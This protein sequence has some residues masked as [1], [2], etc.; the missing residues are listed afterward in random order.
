MNLTARH[1][2]PIIHQLNPKAHVIIKNGQLKAIKAT[3][4][5][6]QHPIHTL[7]FEVSFYFQSLTTTKPIVKDAPIYLVHRFALYK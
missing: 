4:R 7:M 2:C 5:L 3:L 6:S 1:R